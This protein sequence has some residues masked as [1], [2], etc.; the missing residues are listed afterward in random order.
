MSMSMKRSHLNLRG[1]SGKSNLRWGGMRNT[2]SLSD[3]AIFDTASKWGPSQGMRG[4]G[5]T[6]AHVVFLTYFSQSSS[7][8]CFG[9]ASKARP[10]ARSPI[11]ESRL[12]RAGFV[13]SLP[14]VAA[15]FGP[16]P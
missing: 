10:P 2:C 13:A 15:A 4:E 3:G 16:K 1:A 9:T 8:T 7:G 14:A 6:K 11:V 5:G 12:K